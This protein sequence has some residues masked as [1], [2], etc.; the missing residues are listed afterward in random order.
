MLIFVS[1]TAINIGYSCKLLTD[2]MP[3]IYVVDGESYDEVE[4]QLR[5]ARSEML[6]MNKGGV[7]DPVLDVVSFSNGRTPTPA[8][9]QPHD[10]N[11]MGNDVT[12]NQPF[13]GFALV[14]NGHSLVSVCSKHSLY[15]CMNVRRRFSV[16]WHVHSMITT[17]AS[18]GKITI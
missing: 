2:E 18:F 12:E 5:D 10:T 13:G 3:E 4:K 9:H 16:N 7:L 17:F 14:I 8:F 1:E 11:D 6:A 15:P